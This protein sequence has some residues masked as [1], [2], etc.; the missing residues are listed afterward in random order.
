MS[1]WTYIYGSLYG[2]VSNFETEET[3]KKMIGEMRLWKDAMSGRITQ[4][5]WQDAFDKTKNPIPMGSEGSVTYSL[6]FLSD[7][8]RGKTAYL[9]F[10]GALRDYGDDE[11][12][13]PYIRQWFMS[14]FNRMYLPKAYLEIIAPGSNLSYEVYD[15]NYELCQKGN[16]KAYR[17]LEHKRG[18]RVTW[19]AADEL[20]VS[21]IVRI[22]NKG[23]VR[24]AE[25]TKEE[26]LRNKKKTGVD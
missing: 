19:L 14:I 5:Q 23:K 11:N 15:C 6:S 10:Y 7:D 21:R 9:T 26:K 1:T 4:E 24:N 18:S 17:F 16:D 12:D 20:P 13:I 3:L 8:T 2:E 22:T 25:K